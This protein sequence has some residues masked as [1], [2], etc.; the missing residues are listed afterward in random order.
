MDPILELSTGRLRLRQWVAE[1]REPFAAMNSDPAVMRYFAGVSTREASD[2]TFDT[3]QAEIRQRGWS[4][5]AV[6]LAQGKE[7]IGFVGLTVPWRV[8]PFAPCVEIGWR[9]AR[10]HWGRGYA[11]EAA[12]RVLEA[13]FAQI[14]LQEIVSF[15]SLVNTPSRAVMERIGMINTGQDFDHPASPES[16]ELRRH[17]LYKITRAQWREAGRAPGRRRALS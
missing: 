5:W 11:T 9:L 14:G 15:T 1:D 13:G 4:N 16:S 8:L 17:C 3:W 2:R 6:E 7:F 12:T 10:A